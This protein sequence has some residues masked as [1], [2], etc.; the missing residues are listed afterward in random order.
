M[1]RFRKVLLLVVLLSFSFF[2]LFSKTGVRIK[3]IASIYGPN[4]L[5][6]TGI[7]LVVGLNGSGDTKNFKITQKL[8]YDLSKPYIEEKGSSNQA[9]IDFDLLG[10]TDLMNP[11][12]PA[13]A[14][15]ATS[16]TRP[17]VTIDNLKPKNVA[18]VVVTATISPF[19]R[20]GET[21]DLMV[22]SIG[23]AKNITSGLLL[24]TELK[25][26]LGNIYA[27]GSGRVLV[28]NKANGGELTGSIPQGASL[29]RDL[30][31][32]DI[33]ASDKIS[34]SLKSP[35]FTTAVNVRDMVKSLNS[36]LTVVA[37]DSGLVEVTLTETEAADKIGFI[38]KLENLIVVPDGVALV[39]IDKKSG[40]I[41]AGSD[42]IIQECLVSVPNVQVKVRSK[43]SDAP[44]RKTNFEFK[45]QNIGELVQMLN[46]LGLTP[47]EIIS[48]IESAH[49]AGGLNA[50]LIIL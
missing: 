15:E 1:L 9:N 33:Q 5:K 24:R 35:D 3:D 14:R 12:A 49:R 43:S 30:L 7:G 18:A 23:D 34:I 37:V 4:E 38:S 10:E 20:K 22:S 6:V 46:E 25:D 40:I 39:V 13:M 50:K 47:A 31:F 19:S 41:V 44:A 8:I 11:Q 32:Q 48:I 26:D 21:I 29:Q 28:G 36:E 16:D 2:S 17:L 45:N 42:V 27:V